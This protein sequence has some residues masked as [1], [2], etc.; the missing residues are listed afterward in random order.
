MVLS[1]SATFMGNHSRCSPSLEQNSNSCQGTQMIA[2]ER[3][4]FW[5]SDSASKVLQM[6]LAWGE[7]VS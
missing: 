3:M 6:P 7:G 5:L 4:K 2:Q 1:E